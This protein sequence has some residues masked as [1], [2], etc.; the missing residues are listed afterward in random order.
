MLIFTDKEPRGLGHLELD[1]RAVDAPLP[2]GVPKYFEC[3]TYTC[4]H[5]QVVVL[6]NP[7]RARERYKCAGCNHHICDNCAADSAAGIPCKTFAQKVE[8]EMERAIRQ[9][10]STIILP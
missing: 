9:P 3:D 7:E 6:M 10:G 5:C 1:Q 4:S 8:A 2:A